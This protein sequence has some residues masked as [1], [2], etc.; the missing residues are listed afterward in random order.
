M[1]PGNANRLRIPRRHLAQKKLPNTTYHNAYWYKQYTGHD[2]GSQANKPEREN[3]F[4]LCTTH[5]HGLYQ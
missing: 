2:R 3:R 1:A 4:T 5:Q